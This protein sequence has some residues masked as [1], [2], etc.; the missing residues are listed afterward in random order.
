MRPTVRR[1]SRRG[2]AHGAEGYRQKASFDQK[3][4]LAAAAG[5]DC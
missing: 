3:L 4:F 2:T 1:A 5:A